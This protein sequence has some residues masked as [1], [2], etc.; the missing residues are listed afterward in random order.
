MTRGNVVVDWLKKV[1]THL[2]VHVYIREH[3]E[4]ISQIELHKTRPF[5]M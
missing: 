2:Q 5:Y 4:L 1:G 3:F